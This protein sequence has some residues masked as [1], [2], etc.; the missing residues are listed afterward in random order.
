MIRLRFLNQPMLIDTSQY[1]QPNFLIS[2]TYVTLVTPRNVTFYITRCY[3]LSTKC[4]DITVH[5]GHNLP[6][7]PSASDG[8][9]LNAPNNLTKFFLVLRFQ[10]NKIYTY[11]GEVLVSVNPYKN[12]DIYNMQHMA[13][14][15]GREMF[16]VTPHVYAVA[17]A[18]QRV[19]RQQV[20]DLHHQQPDFT[21]CWAQ[22]SFC[23]CQAPRSFA[24]LIQDIPAML[25]MSFIHLAPGRPAPRFPELGGHSVTA[26][27]PYHHRALLGVL[28]ILPEMVR[29]ECPK[30]YKVI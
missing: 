1:F 11:I 3:I 12:L 6:N 22:A 28:G 30:K 5:C 7:R 21:N 9:I 14:Y 2:S 25:T 10:H 18:C 20:R 16:E 15:R 27:L 4:H 17:D 19:L 8:S 29:R 24:S 13:Q 26:L 23:L